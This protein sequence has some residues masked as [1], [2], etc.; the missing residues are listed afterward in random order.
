[1]RK[2]S[3]LLPLMFFLTSYLYC[4]TNVKDF[5]GI[6]IS[7]EDENNFQ[8][9]NNGRSLNFYFM[10]DDVIIKPKYYGFSIG[11]S[12]IKADALGMNFIKSLATEITANKFF[13]GI[14]DGNINFVYDFEMTQTHL[15]LFGNKDLH[16]DKIEKLPPHL[17]KRLRRECKKKKKDIDYF[18]GKENK[19]L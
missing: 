4:Q 5:N 12:S 2:T 3:L 14:G 11:I 19:Y 1:M 10:S 17:E 8:I 7:S 15:I 16:F 9:M 13:L 6:W 18:L